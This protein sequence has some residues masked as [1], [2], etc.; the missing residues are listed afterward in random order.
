M[1]IVFMGTPDFAI[2]SLSI[3]LENGYDIAA[4]VTA[5]DK[6]AGRGRKV[7][8]PALKT[9]ALKHELPVLQP[10]RLKDPAFLGELKA[11]R[12]ELFIV[13]AFRMLP[14]VVWQMPP[15]G[16]FNLH[17]SLLPQ[18]RGAAPIN[19][20]IMNGES[21]TGLTTFFLQHEIDT[22]QILLQDRVEIGGNETAGELHDRLMDKGAQLV[23]QTVRAIEDGQAQG[24]AQDTLVHAEVH[25]GRELKQAPKLYKEDCRINWH[26]SLDEIHNHI[27]GLSPYPAAFTELNGKSL[28]IFSS[29]KEESIHQL[30]PG[31]FISDEKT[32]M[33]VAVQGG[34]I[35]IGELQL[36]GKRRMGIAE[37]LKGYRLQGNAHG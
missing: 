6:A 2:P 5:P 26:R 4:V 8:M 11:L 30:P 9:F 19:R 36:E 31:R 15:L 3:L 17:A 22:G 34:F 27:R 37:F 35:D 10:E 16:T 20:A 21:E 23:L 7:R 25:A 12:A 33:K 32:Y 18:Y 13:V 29:T 14:E 1:R 28:K 24:V